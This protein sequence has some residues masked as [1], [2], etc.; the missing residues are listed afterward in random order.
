LKSKS[1]E[2]KNAFVE[3]VTVIAWVMSMTAFAI[4]YADITG[5]TSDPDIFIISTF[6]VC[7]GFFSYWVIRTEP[8]QFR[9]CYNRLKDDVDNEWNER[10]MLI[11]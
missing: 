1:K 3:S 6:F 7:I 11:T 2:F 5:R 10:T 9:E 4:P 8:R